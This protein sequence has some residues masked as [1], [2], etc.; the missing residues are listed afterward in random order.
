MSIL[1]IIMLLCFGAAWPFSIYRSWKSSTTGGK[2]VFFLLII[3]LGYAA[4]IANKLLYRF[5]NVLYLYCLNL[6]M[7]LIDTILWFRNKKKEKN[8]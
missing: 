3:I 4:G 2:S 1:E 6:L 8:S 7:V 5:D